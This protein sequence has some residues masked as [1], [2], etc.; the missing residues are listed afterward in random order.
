MWYAFPVFLHR[1]A[2]M[3]LMQIT[4]VHSSSAAAYF[5]FCCVIQFSVLAFVL[6]VHISFR[7]FIACSLHIN[8]QRVVK[9]SSLVEHFFHFS[10][11]I[12]IHLHP[13]LLR[14]VAP[15]IQYLI[16]IG[17]LNIFLNIPPIL[18]ILD[19]YIQTSYIV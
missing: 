7:R 2:N 14:L 13:E 3:L 10:N 11:R 12:N 5:L 16:H 4:L 8:I 18:I 15:Y 19:F 1:L 17:L 9:K 6:I